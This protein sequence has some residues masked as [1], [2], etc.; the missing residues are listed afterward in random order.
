M[1]RLSNFFIGFLCG[2]ILF[3]GTIALANSGV[4]AQITTQLFFYNGEPIELLA[5]NINGNNYVKLRDAAALFGVD[6][7]YSRKEF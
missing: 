3:G 7:E 5:Y 6:I 2:A 1:K 4:L